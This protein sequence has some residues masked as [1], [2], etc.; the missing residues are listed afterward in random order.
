MQHTIMHAHTHTH[1]DLYTISTSP[2]KTPHLHTYLL[3]PLFPSSH[4]QSPQAHIKLSTHIPPKRWLHP[5]YAERGV[6]TPPLR[7]AHSHI[8]FTS[9]F[10]PLIPTTWSTPTPQTTQHCSQRST[11]GDSC[12]LAG[13]HPEKIQP[14]IC[15]CMVIWCLHATIQRKLSQSFTSPG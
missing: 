3:L 14:V 13:Y 12:Q 8:N 9:I 2:Q 5:T 11:G 7:V 1:Q 10:T 6:T 15:K 4:A